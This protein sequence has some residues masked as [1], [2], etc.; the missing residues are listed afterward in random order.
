MI[1]RHLQLDSFPVATVRE[2]N[3]QVSVY[4]LLLTKVKLKRINGTFKMLRTFLS[5]AHILACV[6][7]CEMPAFSRQFFGNS[8]AIFALA[9]NQR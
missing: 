3:S 8:F 2:I 7:V 4:Y 5:S 1:D 6:A 9:V